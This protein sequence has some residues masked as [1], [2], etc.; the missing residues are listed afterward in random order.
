MNIQTN[1][2][3]TISP[4]EMALID[5]DKAEARCREPE[6]SEQDEGFLIGR[7]LPP[8]AILNISADGTTVTCCAWCETKPQAEAWCRY[9]GY[10]IS[11]GIC[12]TCR[13]REFPE[14]H[15]RRVETVVQQLSEATLRE[16]AEVR[17]GHVWT[18]G[19]SNRMPDD[20]Y[21]TPANYIGVVQ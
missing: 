19:D 13:A 21:V 4:E 12:P 20:E 2:D 7:A 15:V 16:C 1:G 18:K 17:A 3:A 11:H 9:R 5:R 14:I 6:G 10:R 8:S